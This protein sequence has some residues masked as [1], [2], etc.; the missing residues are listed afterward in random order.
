MLRRAALPAPSGRDT[1]TIAADGN[2][3]APG[4]RKRERRC[5]TPRVGHKHLH[6]Y[7]WL[8]W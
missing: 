6:F 5:Q 1:V 7:P 4:C 8:F 3:L 2:A